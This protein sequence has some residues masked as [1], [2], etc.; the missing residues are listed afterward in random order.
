MNVQ[1]G[2]SDTFSMYLMGVMSLVLGMIFRVLAILCML[3]AIIG[4]FWETDQVIN[5]F[6]MTTST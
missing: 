1:F 6:F 4:S 5:P 3:G 2:D